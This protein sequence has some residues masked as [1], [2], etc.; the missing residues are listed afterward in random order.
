MPISLVAIGLLLVVA[1]FNGTQDKLYSIVRTTYE[2]SSGLG[3]WVVLCL[4]LGVLASVP[5]IK[6][7][8]NAFMI[9]LCI[10]LLLSVKVN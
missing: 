8:V 10:G 1:G 2:K 4:I 9:L 6:E 3:A 7:A 5:E